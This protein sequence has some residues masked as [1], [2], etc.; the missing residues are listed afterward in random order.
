VRA[1]AVE[2]ARA[3]GDVTSELRAEMAWALRDARRDV[4][5]YRE[6]LLAL[7]DR[8]VDHFKPVD[9]HASVA[10]ALILRALAKAGIDQLGAIVALKEAQEH[11][12]LTDDER[13]QV[14][15][16]DEL[17]GAMIFG[18]TPYAEV[19]ELTRREVEWAREHGNAFAI[20]DGR[21]GEAYSL[22]ALGRSDEAL[23]VLDELATFF[24][25][26]PGT[27]S[28]HG[29]CYTIAGRI[30]RD[31]GNP[32]AAER[33]YRRAMEL[34]DL[35]GHRRWWRNAAPGA[36]HALL[37]EGR[38]PE[39]RA[40]LDQIAARDEATVAPGAF[41]LEAEARYELAVGNVDSGIDL[42]RRAVGEVAGSASLLYEGRARETL[43]TLLAAAGDRQ[44][45]DHEL[46]RAREL[47]AA[48]GF[49]VGVER[50]DA[51]S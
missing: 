10:Q 49:L 47:F 2:A 9:D 22:A 31:R 15:V 41:R 27:V 18:P 28:Q 51:R 13:I 25:Q 26:L 30:E 40:V 1:D 34:F 14:D 32:A 7:A 3:V 50:I 39:A 12:E 38:L 24:G 42:A 21:L 23:A 17:G 44:G 33:R 6:R 35:G 5:G 19:L 36:A 11:A 46:A 8:A 20:A 16:W 43:A 29:E 45:A 48:K 37:D 4:A